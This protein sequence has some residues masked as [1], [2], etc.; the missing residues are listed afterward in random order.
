LKRVKTIQIKD[1][2]E[3][4]FKDIDAHCSISRSE[5]YLKILI[6][7]SPDS[8]LYRNVLAILL[9]PIL[10]MFLLVLLIN[11][12][13]GFI[14]LTT[15]FTAIS[16]FFILYLFYRN[17]TKEWRLDKQSNEIIYDQLTPSKKSLNTL[18]FSEIEYL[19][20][21]NYK[22][23]SPAVSMYSLLF[24]LKNMEEVQIFLGKKEK[25]EELGIIMVDFLEKPLYKNIVGLREKII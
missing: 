18:S 11:Y 24:H 3:K 6:D 8:K 20:Y 1:N 25:C 4:F 10:S 5:N 15:L 21:T 23:G 16:P 14:F 22:W 17:K 9:I 13:W 2:G 7:F 12:N 19:I